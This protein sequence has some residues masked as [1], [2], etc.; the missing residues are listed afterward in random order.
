VGRTEALWLGD[1]RQIFRARGLIRSRKRRD[2]TKRSRLG[3]WRRQRLP[4]PSLLSGWRGE[5][6]AE[7]GV[8][9]RD[10][11]N[12]AAPSSAAVMW[13]GGGLAL[14]SVSSTGFCRC[15]C[16]CAAH[17]C[18]ASTSRHE[19]AGA[20]PPPR[21]SHGIPKIQKGLWPLPFPRNVIVLPDSPG[22]HH[23]GPRPHYCVHR[24]PATSYFL[25][26]SISLRP[27]PAPAAASRDADGM[28]ISPVI[29]FWSGLE[30]FYPF[31]FY[32]RYS[33]FVTDLD[34]KNTFLWCR[35]LL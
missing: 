1:W 5:W 7:Q 27:P 25:L 9:A 26:A 16:C 34:T 20:G 23:A 30:E 35:Y 33:I 2:W 10:G 31:V 19:E 14:G 29:Q 15:G 11:L 22:P 21:G 8:W 6:V 12:A 13:C 3:G 4:S 24:K 32:F 17:D 18:R 28:D